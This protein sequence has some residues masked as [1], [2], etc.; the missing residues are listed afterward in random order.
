LTDQRLQH[1]SSLTALQHLKLRRC[2]D[3]TARA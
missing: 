1:L 2:S 3:L